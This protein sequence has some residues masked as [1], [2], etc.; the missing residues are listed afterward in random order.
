MWE[1]LRVIEQFFGRGGT[2]DEPAVWVASDDDV[3][4]AVAVLWLGVRVLEHAPGG[5][6]HAGRW[7][8]LVTNGRGN[9]PNSTGKRGIYRPVSA[10]SDLLGE[11]EVLN[12]N[13]VLED[14]SPRPTTVFFHL[15]EVLC[16][17]QDPSNVSNIQ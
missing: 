7:R 14:S 17:E 5:N 6:G 2:V 13:F 8:D 9:V 3:R 4:D 1:D 12:R 11:Y 16:P 15:A 10:Q